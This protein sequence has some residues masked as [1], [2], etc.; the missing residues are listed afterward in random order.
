MQSLALVPE[1][2]NSLND[3]SGERLAAI[4][5]LFH[6]KNRQE[7]ERHI[8]NKARLEAILAQTTA[9]NGRVSKL[10]SWKDRI[11]GGWWVIIIASGV[12]GFFVRL[13]FEHH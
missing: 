9:T 2:A 13:I 8:E 3:K 6:E 11:T 7:T 10:E 1:M 4:E 12:I 5:A